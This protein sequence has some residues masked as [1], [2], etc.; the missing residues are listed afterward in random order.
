MKRENGFYWIRLNRWVVAEYGNGLWHF[1]GGSFV[2]Y[3]CRE[4]NENRLEKPK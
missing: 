3:Q 2:D 4:I 1:Q